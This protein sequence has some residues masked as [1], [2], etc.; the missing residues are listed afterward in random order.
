MT[1]DERLAALTMNLELMALDLEA[2]KE[3][4]HA[5][6]EAYRLAREADRL[7]READRQT[8]DEKFGKV[9]AM[10]ENNAIAVGALLEV[11]RI[12]GRRLDKLEG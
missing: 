7:A 11:V 3:R 8:W 10:T 9:L 5:N 4:D 2:L 6:W 12:H 1:V